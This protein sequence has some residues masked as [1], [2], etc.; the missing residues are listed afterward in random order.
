MQSHTP[1]LQISFSRSEWDAGGRKSPKSPGPSFFIYVQNH[2]VGPH[3]A[4]RP[5]ITINTFLCQA[6]C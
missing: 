5:Q 4:L 3:K 2:S 6:L 1:G